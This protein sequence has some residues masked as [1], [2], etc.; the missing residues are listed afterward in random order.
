[1]DYERSY[2]GAFASALFD[3]LEQ[4]DLFDLYFTVSKFEGNMGYSLTENPVGAAMAVNKEVDAADYNDGA[5]GGT[6]DISQSPSRKRSSSKNRSSEKRRVNLSEE[7]RKQESQLPEDMFKRETIP[8]FVPVKSIQHIYQI[9]CDAN[10][11]NKILVRSQYGEDFFK[12]EERKKQ[13][14]LQNIKDD[15]VL[16]QFKLVSRATTKTHNVQTFINVPTSK[17]HDINLQ[18]LTEIISK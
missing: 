17:L 4:T 16:V 15:I 14:Y 2:I 5:L 11:K 6:K 9:F 3:A 18:M 1:M 10:K 7:R 8:E 13:F 12:N